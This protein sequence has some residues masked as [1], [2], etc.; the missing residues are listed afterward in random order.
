MVVRLTEI[1]ELLREQH[2]WLGK[3]DV[4]YFLREYTPGVGFGGSKTNSLISN[5]KKRLNAS[6]GELYYKQQA[7]QQVAREL[8]A[9][10]RGDDWEGTVFVPMPPSVHRDEPEYDDRLVKVL[11]RVGRA[12]RAE[13]RELLVTTRSYPAV[14]RSAVRLSPSELLDLMEVDE[15]Q[16]EPAPERVV[17]FDDVITAG[18]HFV[19]ARKI[20]EQRFPGVEV[21][22]LFVA[23]TMHEEGRAEH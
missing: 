5:L 9:V 7:I 14:S 11:R 6:K 17:V 20:L 10:L 18:A 1:D 3:R 13:V 4:C 16:A 21:E 19:A 8:T 12:I 2:Y 23:R 22:G 15:D